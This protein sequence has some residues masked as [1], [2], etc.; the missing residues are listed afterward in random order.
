MHFYKA[1]CETYPGA[2]TYFTTQTL[3]HLGSKLMFNDVENWP[4]VR[5]EL[6][7]IDTSKECIASMLN[8]DGDTLTVAEWARQIGMDQELFRTRLS[9]G[10]PVDRIVNTPKLI[11]EN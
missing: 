5:I 6:I 11:R 4:N 10:W 7:E 3:A 8:G 2:Y 1:T 9:R